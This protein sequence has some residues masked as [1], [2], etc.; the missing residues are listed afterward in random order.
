MTQ[1]GWHSHYCVMSSLPQRV[2]KH[3]KTQKESGK[4]KSKP[5]PF[6]RHNTVL[7]KEEMGDSIFRNKSPGERTHNSWQQGG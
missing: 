7:D 6:P 3:Y 5:Y 2:R 4:D 1:Q